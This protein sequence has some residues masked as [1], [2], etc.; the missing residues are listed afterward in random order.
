ML[1]IVLLSE[2]IGTGHEKA[3]SAIEEAFLSRYRDVRVT[4]LNLLDTFRPLTAKV[5]RTLYLETLARRPRLWG[6]WYEW[7]REK[8]MNGISR[9]I[10]HGILKKDVGSWLNRLSPD[11]VVCT[12]PLPACLIGEMKRKGLSVPLCTVLTD[13]DMHGYWA[14]PGVDLYCVPLH[15]TAHALRRRLRERTGIR[16]TGI[17][18]SRAFAHG[19]A[20]TPVA[21]S[22]ANKRIL[23]MGGGLGIGVMETVRQIAGAETD[24]KPEGD[25]GGSSG[26]EVTVVCGNNRSLRRELQTRYGNRKNFEILGYTAEI[27]RLMAGSHLLVSKPGGLTIAEAL[28][29]R[30]PM[31][32]CPAIHGQEWR[33]AQLMSELGA[34]VAVNTAKEAADAVFGL[35][36]SDSVRKDIVRRMDAVRRPDAAME[37]AGAVMEI[38]LEKRNRK[39]ALRMMR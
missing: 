5:T 29:M 31:V 39:A 2:A 10:V 34:A 35:L 3:A 8:E 37:V 19:S 14:H 12:H 20:A 17:P 18:V 22:P 30:L 15:E 13:F 25:G 36:G 11:A 9:T 16:I 4:R 1:H 38:A 23:V 7:Q 21:D 6:K 33:N 28:A 26:F 27:P 32:L 24:G